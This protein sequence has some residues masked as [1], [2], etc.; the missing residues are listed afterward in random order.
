MKR[1]ILLSVLLVLAG[2]ATLLV[3]PTM[4]PA[5]SKTNNAAVRPHKVLSVAP[6]IFDN[7]EISASLIQRG[8]DINPVPLNLKDKNR[9]L[10]GLGSYIVNTSGCNDCHTN[11]SYTAGGDPFLGQP[12]QINVDCFLSGGQVFGPFTSRNLTPNAQGLPAG[13]T[14]EEFIHTLRTGEDL[15]SPGDPPFDGGLLQVM[16][17]PVF[18]KKTDRELTAIYEY[19]RAIPRKARCTTA[20]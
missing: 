20:P 16:P 12:E 15:D 5:L 19:L 3:S 11:P 2:V 13:L 8:F 18:G 10:V 7:G 1:Q 17:W 9:A 6:M 4:I 14:L